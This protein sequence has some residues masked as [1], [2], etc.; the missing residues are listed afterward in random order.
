MERKLNLHQ[1]V[2]VVLFLPPTL[3]PPARNF[4]N[5]FETDDLYHE[6]N[7]RLLRDRAVISE[8]GLLCLFWQMVIINLLQDH[9]CFLCAIR[10]TF[11]HSRLRWKTRITRMQFTVTVDM[12][13]FLVV[14]SI[15]ILP[16][17]RNQTPSPT[18]ILITP[19]KLHLDTLTTNPTH[20]PSWQEAFTS[21]HQ[22]SKSCI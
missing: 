13:L 4:L 17:M 20:D 6:W 11:H 5:C 18:R 16:T 2:K 9:S 7:T 1:G 10:M 12:D 3:A 15:C 22:K 8:P 19:T 21:L 14:V